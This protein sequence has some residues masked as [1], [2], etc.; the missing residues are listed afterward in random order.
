MLRR[1][2]VAKQCRVGQCS[3]MSLDETFLLVRRASA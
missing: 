2:R 3:G 1:R